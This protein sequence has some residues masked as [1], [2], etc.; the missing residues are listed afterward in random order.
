MPGGAI[1]DA[2]LAAGADLE[3]SMPLEEYSTTPTTA[4]LRASCAPPASAEW[5]FRTA[6][7]RRLNPPRLDDALRLAA[8]AAYPRAVATCVAAGGRLAVA[9]AADTARRVL[10]SLSDRTLSDAARLR[11]TADALE[12]APVGWRAAGRAYCDAFVAQAASDA[13]TAAAK[14]SAAAARL[15]DC[16]FAQ[17]G[18][19]H[20]LL[21]VACVALD[22]RD[23]IASRVA[24]DALLPTHPR[25]HFTS[26]GCDTPPPPRLGK[27]LREDRENVRHWRLM[28]DGY[29]AQAQEHAAFTA[30]CDA[31]PPL[32]LLPLP[33]TSRGGEDDSA[34]DGAAAD[35]DVDASAVAVVACACSSACVPL[36]PAAV[37]SSR[38]LRRLVGDGAAAQP[39]DDGGGAVLRVPLPFDAP[40]VRAFAAAAEAVTDGHTGGFHALVAAAAGL[41]APE[42]RCHRAGTASSR[43]SPPRDSRLLRALLRVLVLADFLDAPRVLRTAVDAVADELD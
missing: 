4:W 23:G 25:G 22:S 6:A 35:A 34:S 41:P 12:G 32:P 9:R 36:P 15:A 26:P 40:T 29:A 28:R 2:L 18:D 14:A 10:Q 42:G 5:V 3:A 39:G 17:A 43:P 31:R 20:A 37:A 11:A 21:R 16:E 7:A 8:A 38:V 30:A 1:C 13:A 33:Q 24:M 27:R 19:A